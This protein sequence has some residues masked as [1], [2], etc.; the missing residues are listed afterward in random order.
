MMRYAIGIDL[1]GTNIAA[2]LVNEKYE[3]MRKAS[4]PT[5]ADRPWQEIVADMAALALRLMKIGRASCRERV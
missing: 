2:G 5:G 4:Q 1:G 3:F